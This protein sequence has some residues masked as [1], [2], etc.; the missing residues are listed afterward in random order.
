MTLDSD[1][2]GGREAGRAA[3]LSVHYLLN[4]KDTEKGEWASESDG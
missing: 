2:E 3:H 1:K 4:A